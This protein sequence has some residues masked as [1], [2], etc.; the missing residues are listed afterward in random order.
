MS[1]V[2]LDMAMS[3]DGFAV[4]RDGDSLYPVEDIKGT[5]CIS[6]TRFRSYR[7]SVTLGN[8]RPN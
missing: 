3:L 7:K 6:S 8:K 5:L 4:D 1:D 2:L